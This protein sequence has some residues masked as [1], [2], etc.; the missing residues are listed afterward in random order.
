MDSASPSIASDNECDDYTH[1]IFFLAVY[2]NGGK[3]YGNA[4]P[5]SPLLGSS[6][7]R[8]CSTLG[9]L[10][11]GIYTAEGPDIA[12]HRAKHGIQVRVSERQT[13]SCCRRIG[14]VNNGFV[15][16]GSKRDHSELRIAAAALPEGGT[17]DTARIVPSRVGPCLDGVGLHVAR[18]GLSLYEERGGFTRAS[19]EIELAALDY[20][21][22]ARDGGMTVN[23][24]PGG[25]RLPERTLRIF[26]NHRR[27]EP[28]LKKQ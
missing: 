18:C 10:L 4:E 13:L 5:S 27:D 22:V 20:C 3:T 21:L 19:C 7:E 14:P 12:A 15:K 24:N 26:S 17:R 1:N 25:E 11:L 8:S 6:S 9:A 16:D 28:T 2:E 23:H